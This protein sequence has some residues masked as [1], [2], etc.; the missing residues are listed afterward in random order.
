MEASYSQRFDDRDGSHFGKCFREENIDGKS[1]WR[2][3]AGEEANRGDALITYLPYPWVEVQ[4]L[5]TH[6]TF[7]TITCSSRQVRKSSG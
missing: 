1:S 7:V 2:K 3:D 6:G 5:Q 4:F